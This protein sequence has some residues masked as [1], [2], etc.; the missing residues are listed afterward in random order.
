[1]LNATIFI[2]GFYVIEKSKYREIYDKNINKK[3]KCYVNKV[4][5]IKMLR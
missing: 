4:R 3:S 5:S 1:M 2:G